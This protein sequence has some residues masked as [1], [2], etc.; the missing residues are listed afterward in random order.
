[1]GVLPKTD[2]SQKGQLTQRRKEAKAQG[3]RRLG[4]GGLNASNGSVTAEAKLA[5]CARPRAQ[6]WWKVTE[7]R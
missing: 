3:T 2:L 6:Q 1:M 7:M 4:E 5:E